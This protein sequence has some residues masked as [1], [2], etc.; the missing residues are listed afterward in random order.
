MSFCQEPWASHSFLKEQQEDITVKDGV[1]HSLLVLGE[2]KQDGVLVSTDIAD[3]S[4][5]ASYLPY[6]R[7]I[8]LLDQYPALAAFNETMGRISRSYVQKAIEGQQNGLYRILKYDLL[9]S[10]EAGGSKWELML[11][12]LKN[13]PE[14]SY[15]EYMDEELFIKLNERYVQE[16]AELPILS[17]READIK[18]ARH[19][20]WIL[21]TE[22]GRQAVFA[23][24]DLSGLDL[25]HRNLNQAVFTGSRMTGTN[26]E[27]SE[28]CFSD[29][30]NVQM[31]NC[32]LKGITAEEARFQD[33][34]MEHCDCQGAYFTHSDFTNARIMDSCL[35]HSKWLNCY[36]DRIV[37]RNTSTKQAVM[38]KIF[39]QQC[40]EGTGKPFAAIH[41]HVEGED[42]YF[43][44]ESCDSFYTTASRYENELR[45]DAE[46][47]TLDSLALSF[48]ETQFLNARIFSALGRAMLVDEHIM[49]VKFDFDEKMVSV[50]RQKD[51]QWHS[52]SLED[53][54]EAVRKAEK[55]QGLPMDAREEV[56]E[57]ALREKEQALEI[58][59]YPEMLLK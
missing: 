20:L 36:G 43:T 8:Y 42:V 57:R 26:L 33:V 2:G 51:M 30:S 13:R 6:A 16:D 15:L 21:G 7:Q 19:L 25:S 48:G 4:V 54:G 3:R 41:L 24:Y 40:R 49:L 1:W 34:F 53:V 14:L 17:Q 12:M 59:G 5:Y 11:K 37:F 32:S 31:I 35:D 29:F 23:G 38:P 39:R 45:K 46:A 22:E 10:L 47:M 18:C 44:S 58:A 56:F 28:L 55:E 9:E 52:Y 27:E 50:N